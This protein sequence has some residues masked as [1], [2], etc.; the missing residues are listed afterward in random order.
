MKALAD[1]VEMLTKALL[2]KESKP[3][4]TKESDPRKMKY[5]AFKKWCKENGHDLQKGEDREELIVNLLQKVLEA[6]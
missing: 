2:E 4:K 6:K 5:M 1:Q 3:K